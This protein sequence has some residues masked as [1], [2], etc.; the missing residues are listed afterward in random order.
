[1]TQPTILVVDDESTLL[2]VRKLVLEAEGFRV[3]SAQNG[4]E[5]LKV[6]SSENVDAVVTDQIMPGMSGTELA[7]EIKQRKPDLPVVMLSALNSAPSDANGVVD[8]FMVKGQAPSV[9]LERLAS[10]LNMQPHSH[11]EFEGKYV[12]FVDQER[13]YIDVTDGVCE[14]LNYSRNSLLKMRIDDV[15]APAEA[16][17]V[18]PLFDQYVA[19]GGL[20]GE[21]LLQTSTGKIIPIR[22]HSRIF[23]DG[24]MVARWEP[25]L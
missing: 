12:A 4:A 9:L 14:L 10:L 20:D 6:F 8:V 15:A 24:C 13:R 23:P 17:N 2:H 22:Y 25:Q 3:L 16:K 18:A 19:T 21:F 7:K 5:A 1:M 11:E